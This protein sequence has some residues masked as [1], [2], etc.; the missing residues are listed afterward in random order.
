MP[1]AFIEARLRKPKLKSEPGRVVE[2][3]DACPMVLRD[4]RNDAE[5]ETV[6][7][8]ESTPFESVEALQDMRSLPGGKARPVIDNCD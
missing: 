6:P 5:P 3:F 2:H 7:R 8:G 1:Y 4:C